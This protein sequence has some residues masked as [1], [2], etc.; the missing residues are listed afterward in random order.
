MNGDIDASTFGWKEGMVDWV[1]LANE[2]SLSSLFK[3]GTTDSMQDAMGW[4]YVDKYRQKQGPVSEDRLAALLKEFHLNGDTLVWRE[5]MGE[6][7]RISETSELGPLLALQLVKETAAD[8]VEDDEIPTHDKWGKKR[9]QLEKVKK[10]AAKQKEQ[11]EKK[12]RKEVT[13]TTTPTTTSTTSTDDNSASTGG[14]KPSDGTGSKD[15]DDEKK[16]SLPV[17]QRLSRIIC[18]Y[19]SSKCIGK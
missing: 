7:S 11:Q 12:A 9:K 8:D 6:W 16:V 19:V 3:P 10:A 1:P 2:P 4:Y 17:S 15:G 13:S 5:G 14:A 18:M